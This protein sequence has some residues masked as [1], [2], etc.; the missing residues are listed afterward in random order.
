MNVIYIIDDARH[1]DYCCELNNYVKQEDDIIILTKSCR[2]AIYGLIK[3]AMNRIPID[4][5][6]LDHDLGDGQDV[7]SFLNWLIGNVYDDDVVLDDETFKWI[8]DIIKESEWM[9]HTSNT[10]MIPSMKSKIESIKE[11]IRLLDD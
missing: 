4:I 1:E 3:M 8:A 7:S 11:R 9:I 6:M 2:S 10:G 5:I